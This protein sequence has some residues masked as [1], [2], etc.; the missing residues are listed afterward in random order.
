MESYSRKT[1]RPVPLKS[2][3][4]AHNNPWDNETQSANDKKSK[5]PK[6]LVVV[7]NF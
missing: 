4:K 1:K 5:F 2:I 6:Y 7:L 3:H